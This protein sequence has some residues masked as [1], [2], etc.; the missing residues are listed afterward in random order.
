MLEQGRA[1]R[2]GA[3][4]AVR[5]LL[6][7]GLPIALVAIGGWIALPGIDRGLLG[8]GADPRSFTVFALGLGPVVTAYMVVELVALVVPRLSRLRHGDPAGRA[9]LDRAAR[10]TALVLGALQA[11]AVATSLKA[12]SESPL[13]AESSDVSTPIVV[14]SLVGGMCLTL[15]VANIVTRQGIVNGIVLITMLAALVDLRAGLAAGVTKAMLLGTLDATVVAF[16]LLSLALPAVATWLALSR[17]K[18][19]AA[20]NAHAEDAGTTSPYRNARSLAVEPVVPV[21][22]SALAPYAIAPALLMLP[23]TLARFFPGEDALAIAFERLG[24]HW[25]VL[26]LA[27]TLALGVLFARL[28]HRPRE[29]ADLVDRLGGGDRS[30]NEQSA[31]SALRRALVP[32][33]LFLTTLVLAANVRH[34]AFQISILVVP[35]LVAVVMDVV[36]SVRSLAREPSLV[37]IWQER[38]VS[39]LPVLQAVL[40]AE[41]TTVHTRG[42]S[43]LGLLQTFA[44]YASAELLVRAEDA[45][46]ATAVLEHLLLGRPAP[47][48]VATRDAPTAS[49][50]P[51][52][53]HIAA[54]GITAV[55]ALGAVLATTVRVPSSARHDKPRAALEVVRV[56]DTNDA[57]ETVPD[58]AL[59]PDVELRLENVP[60]GRREPARRSTYGVARLAPGESMADASARLGKWLATI[61]LRPGQRFAFEPVED[62]DAEDAHLTVI[63][64]RSFVLTGA[65]I[66]TTADVTDAEPAMDAMQDVHVVVTLSAESADRFADVTDEWTNRRIAILLDGRITSTPVVRTRIGGGRIS[67]TMGRGS[68]DEQ[69]LEARKLA[70]GLSGR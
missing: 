51:G 68:K 65:P 11:F 18:P 31:R 23:R 49:P 35:L 5:L 66:L 24:N 16:L 27:L 39:A 54:L 19:I 53:S 42:T 37:A 29:M 56:D 13:F 36:A 4:L 10:V 8:S 64:V 12:L 57:L 48:P 59:P 34:G 3:S 40:E 6:T 45:P 33:L 63:G 30:R 41:G 70:D 58:G 38:R 47:E 61:P 67:I 28:L 7:F 32:T 14:A 21:P 44:P 69:L 9:K 17:A 62:V 50:A 2:P 15:V 25:L 22:A 46:R 1:T 26:Q 52:R 60:V 20:G 43:V 55:M